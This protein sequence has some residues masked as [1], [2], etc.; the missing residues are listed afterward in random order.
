[1]A[2]AAR[3]IAALM[4]ALLAIGAGYAAR[5]NV[6][7]ISTVSIVVLVAISALGLW[8]LWLAAF[9]SDRINQRVADGIG[10][11]DA[12]IVLVVFAAIVPILWLIRRRH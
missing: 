11:S 7:S 12:G 10:S 9:G 5:S 1:L 8:L 4:G 3:V 2:I 6:G